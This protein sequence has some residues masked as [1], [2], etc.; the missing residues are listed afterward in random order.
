MILCLKRSKS[1]LQELSSSSWF[2]IFGTLLLRNDSCTAPRW[3]VLTV[4][5]YNSLKQNATATAEGFFSKIS[6]KIV[7]EI[8]RP[9]EAAVMAGM[10][11]CSHRGVLFI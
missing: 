4:P 8:L 3:G 2:R 5:M 6:G 9:A 1:E 11:V 10:L 7:E